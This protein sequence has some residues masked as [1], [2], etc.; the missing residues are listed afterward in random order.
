M[1]KKRSF[2]GLI[3]E[4]LISAA[5]TSRGRIFAGPTS[6]V[7]AFTR[8]TGQVQPLTMGKNQDI[9]RTTSD[10]KK[11]RRVK[12]SSVSIR[13][14]RGTWHGR[15]TRGPLLHLTPDCL[16][17]PVGENDSYSIRK[18]HCR[19]RNRTTSQLRSGY[20]TRALT[21]FALSKRLPDAEEETA[22]GFSRPPR[23]VE[24]IVHSQQKPGR[25]HAQPGAGRVAQVRRIEIR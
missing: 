2:A 8:P 17:A 18:S 13:G 6:R 20:A 15:V 22:R 23:Q 12:E 25:P 11:G 3:C 9:R 10:R 19:I 4:A 21:S 24:P 5:A 1:Q 14:F 7:P 16:C